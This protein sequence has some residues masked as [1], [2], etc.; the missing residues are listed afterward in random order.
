MRC[1]GFSRYYEIVNRELRSQES[2]NCEISMKRY[3]KDMSRLLYCLNIHV[4]PY[5]LKKNYIKIL[6]RLK[7]QTKR[8]P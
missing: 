6:D 1:F 5:F 7:K 8:H 3:P 2:L 4:A